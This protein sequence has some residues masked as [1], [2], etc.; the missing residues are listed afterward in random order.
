MGEEDK[1]ISFEET[2]GNGVMNGRFNWLKM[3]MSLNILLLLFS[4]VASS[5]QPQNVPV[6]PNDSII[7]AKVLEYSILNSTLASFF[8]AFTE[9]RTMPK[10]L[11]KIIGFCTERLNKKEE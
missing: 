1:Q 9:A 11:S 4:Q 10:P 5:S 6:T 7:T 2:G 8:G 3:W